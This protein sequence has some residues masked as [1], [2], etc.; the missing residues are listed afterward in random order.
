L[1]KRLKNEVSARHIAGFRLTWFD[2]GPMR[3]T[4]QIVWDARRSPQNQAVNLATNR[5]SGDQ[6]EL[7]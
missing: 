1:K 3:E 2:L 6:I 5:V 4:A 7:I